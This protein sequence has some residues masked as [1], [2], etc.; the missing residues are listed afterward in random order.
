MLKELEPPVGLAALVTPSEIA[1]F[2]AGMLISEFTSSGTIGMSIDKD[3]T[4]F[5]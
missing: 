3:C 2:V 4:H 1:K 5:L